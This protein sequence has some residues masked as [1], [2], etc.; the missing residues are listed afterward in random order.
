MA[1]SAA[2][3][4]EPP[5]VGTEGDSSGN[6]VIR[7]EQSVT[8]DWVPDPGNSYTEST[9]NDE[10]GTTYTFTGPSR[11]GGELVFTGVSSRAPFEVE[12][13][14][15]DAGITGWGGVDPF[16]S[17]VGTWA[18]DPASRKIDGWGGGEIVTDAY[19]GFSGSEIYF[20]GYHDGM[21]YGAG[22][23]GHWALLPEPI[24]VDVFGGD[25]ND[26][27]YGGQG[28]EL[29]SGD[30]GND[31]LWV[32]RGAD[33]ALGGDGRD[34]IHGGIGAQVLDGGTGRDTIIGGAGAQMLLGDAGDD[35][36]EAG[37]GNQT[38]LGGAG[39]DVFVLGRGLHGSIVVSDF[40]PAQ[41]RIEVARGLNGVVLNTPRD[42]LAHV[43]DDAHGEAVLNL[44]A[45]ATVTLSSVSAQRLEAHVQDWFKVV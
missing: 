22:D 5:I 7:V 17:T 28:E 12:P 3:E 38:L 33:T 44:G 35:R 31:V 23:R 16:N 13:S 1:G 25:G 9:T 36:I 39:H 32:G 40:N 18:W 14:S 11:A 19:L 15:Y 21:S 8:F 26:T 24:D 20:G 29:L 43:S 45:G 37:R 4:Y 34:V 30:D 41:D 10:A 27:I 42:L 2:V 6:N